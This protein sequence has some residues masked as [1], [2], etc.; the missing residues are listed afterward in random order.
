M[1][2]LDEYIITQAAGAARSVGSAHRE[3]K[4]EPHAR[5]RQGRKRPCLQFF[6]SGHWF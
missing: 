1:Q 5:M 2:V 4:V 6:Q 3:M